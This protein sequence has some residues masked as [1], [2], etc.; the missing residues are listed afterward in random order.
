MVGRV[1]RRGQYIFKVVTMTNADR[2]FAQ[3]WVEQFR[4]NYYNDSD[5]IDRTALQFLQR[6]NMRPI[7]YAFFWCRTP[8]GESWSYRDRYL[9]VSWKKFAR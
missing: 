9:F 5:N 6:R 8:E 2:L 1:R 4:T 7:G 3:N